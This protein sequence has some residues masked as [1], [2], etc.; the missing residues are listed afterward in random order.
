LHRLAVLLLALVAA[1]CTTAKYR[2]A[3][4]RDAYEILRQKELAVLGQA[5]PF[6]IDTPHTARDPQELAAAEII[7]ERATAADLTLTFPD[8]L[9]QAF[10]ANRQYLS[11]KESLFLTALSLTAERH[12]WTPRLSAEQEANVR[13]LAPGG[14]THGTSGRFSVNQLLK[15]G[16]S[17]GLT[18]ANDLLSLSTSDPRYTASTAISIDL[19]QPLLRGYGA[20]VAAE[21]LTQAERDVI[22]DLRSF[23]RYQRTLAVD[24]A[25]RYYRLLQQQ[26]TVRNEY[27]NYRN[28]VQARERAEALAVDRLPEF[29]VDQTRQDELRARNRYVNAVEQ[30]QA[31][32]DDFKLFLGLPLGT[33]L[34]LAAGAL[35]ELSQQGLLAIPLDEQHATALALAERLDLLNEID[36]YDD[37]KRKIII[38]DDD[39]RTELELFANAS[40]ASTPDRR[41]ERYNADQATGRAGL[42]LK[43]PL[44]RLNER[45]AYRRS[46]IDFERQLRQLALTADQV[47]DDIRSAFRTLN[48]ARQNYQIQQLSADLAARRVE[49]ANLLLQAGRAE[50]RDLLDAQ[51]ASVQAR[52]ALTQALVDYHL[53]RLGFLRDLDRLEIS[54]T[55]LS[56]RLPDAPAAAPAAA[57][58]TLITPDQLF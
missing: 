35:A 54:A 41:W 26:D 45:N 5:S 11:R 57:P 28:L 46:L 1:G 9:A 2:A 6:T 25:S 58:D 36:R 42:R 31:T 56:G 39:L 8:A 24:T 4:E 30:Y 37:A 43:L 29:Q 22:Y 27:G 48:N 19:V 15:S 34:R 21:N 16:G 20:E 23:S 33:R 10:S 14:S 51:S 32:L 12:R 3:A 13:R 17:V 55:G 47:R 53:A 18:L 7:G 38:A 40:L 49:S 52:N 44:D 50:T